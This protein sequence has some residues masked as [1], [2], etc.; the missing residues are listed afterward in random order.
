[1]KPPVEQE[2][3]HEDPAIVSISSQIPLE[4]SENSESD[5]PKEITGKQ[6]K[7]KKVIDAPHPETGIATEEPEKEISQTSAKLVTQSNGENKPQKISGT[8][9][10]AK[11]VIDAPLPET[12]FVYESE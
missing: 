12:G 6:R 1:M 7:A 11:K 9:K 10:K 8:R 5:M 4:G 3:V 2:R